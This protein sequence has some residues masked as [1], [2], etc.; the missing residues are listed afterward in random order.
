MEITMPSAI[1]RKK[2][3]TNRKNVFF[4]FALISS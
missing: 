4:L 3:A 1:I 2:K